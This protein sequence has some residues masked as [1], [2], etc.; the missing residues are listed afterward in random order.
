MWKSSFARVMSQMISMPPARKD[1]WSWRGAARVVEGVDTPK[2][3]NGKRR[4]CHGGVVDF[5]IKFLD[6]FLNHFLVNSGGREGNL[7][8]EAQ[9]K[10]TL[11]GDYSFFA[12]MGL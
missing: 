2:K 9:T 5:S 12:L 1:P 6:Q 8:R 10:V 11:P 7:S 3:D 4:G